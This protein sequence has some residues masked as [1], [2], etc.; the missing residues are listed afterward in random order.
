VDRVFAVVCGKPGSRE[1]Y[2]P[3]APRGLMAT[4]QDQATADLLACLRS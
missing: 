1:I 4:H 2:D 3:G